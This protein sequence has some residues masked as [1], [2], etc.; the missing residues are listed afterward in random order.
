M[1]SGQLPLKGRI[2]KSTNHQSSQFH[3]TS[4]G[5]PETFKHWTE[6]QMTKAMDTV[7]K[8]HY[9]FRRAA[10]E[11]S[12]PRQTLHDHVRERV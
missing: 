11:F 6:T 8:Q 5:K 3:V 12:V 7:Q 9:S 10:E 2:L 1:Y 4:V